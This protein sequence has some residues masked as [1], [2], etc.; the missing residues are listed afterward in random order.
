MNL[1]V[2]SHLEIR[3]YFHVALVFGSHFF[4]PGCVEE[5]SFWILLEMTSSGGSWKNFSYF[6]RS[7]CRA[8]RTWRIWTLL[9]RSPVGWTLFVQC[10]ADSGYIYLVSSWRPFDE[11]PKFSTCWGRLGSCGRFTSCSSGVIS[12]LQHGEA[13]TVDASIA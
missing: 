2:L 12:R 4:C 7:V 10:L 1:P 6:Q 11:F 13:C 5:H 8:V 9:L 3:K